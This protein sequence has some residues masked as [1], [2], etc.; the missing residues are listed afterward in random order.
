M[1][2][3][4]CV[5]VLVDLGE[6]VAEQLDY[7]PG[8]LRVIRHWWLKKA[9]SVSTAL[10]CGRQAALAIQS[11]EFRHL[12]GQIQITIMPHVHAHGRPGSGEPLTFYRRHCLLLFATAAM[13]GNF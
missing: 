10:V 6:N 11:I 3:A 8:H 2:C 4:Q 5:G 13:P 9:V 12:T 7:V 1:C